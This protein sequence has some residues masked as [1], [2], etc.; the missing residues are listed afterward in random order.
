VPLVVGG[1][2][3]AAAIT[4]AAV[5]VLGG[6]GGDT[7]DAATDGSVTAT[8]PTATSDVGTTEPESP[9]TDP[10]TT[11]PATTEPVTTE[12]ATTEPATGPPPGAIGVEICAPDAT[13][14]ADIASVDDAMFLLVDGRPVSVDRASVTACAIDPALAT[15]GGFVWDQPVTHLAGAGRPLVLA[16][17]SGG[18]VGLSGRSDVIACAPLTGFTTANNEIRYFVLDA[19][20]IVTVQ[21]DGDQCPS[22]LVL[23]ADEFAAT[24]ILAGRNRLIA[25]GSEPDGSPGVR[26]W[27]DQRPVTVTAADGGRPVFGSIDGLVGCDALSC[28]ID[29]ATSSVHQIGLDAVVAWTR[30]IDTTNATITEVLATTTQDAIP[31]LLARLDDGSTVIARLVL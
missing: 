29:L 16:G 13:G 1:L 3:A 26:L 19:T 21:L 7:D 30:P 22:S 5:L 14:I 24:S 20:G 25:G 9:T 6:G 31:Y 15:A 11:E 2:V 8:A 17:P 18:A 12:P 23:A 27:D 10:A 4:L 28:V